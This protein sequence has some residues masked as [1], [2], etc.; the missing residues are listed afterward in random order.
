L[1]FRSAFNQEDRRRGLTVW[2]GVSEESEGG[3]G[4]SPYTEYD[5]NKNELKKYSRTL[6]VFIVNSIGLCD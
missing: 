3:Q 6:L 5:S 2:V 1:D 4:V